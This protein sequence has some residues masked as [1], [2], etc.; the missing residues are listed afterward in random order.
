VIT[1][2]LL[3]PTGEPAQK[4]EGEDEPKRAEAEGCMLRRRVQSS[5]CRV[6]GVGFGVQS[7]EFSGFRVKSVGF[8]A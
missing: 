5:G 8:R 2:G 6:Q 7:S 1:L 4:R 3:V